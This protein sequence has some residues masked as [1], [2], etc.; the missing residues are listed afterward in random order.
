MH[1]CILIYAFYSIVY[2]WATVE[3]SCWH[4]GKGRT[5]VKYRAAIKVKNELTLEFDKTEFSLK[6]ENMKK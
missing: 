4:F 1:V 3:T 6:Y 2:I 5:K